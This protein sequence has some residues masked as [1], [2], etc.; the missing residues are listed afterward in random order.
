MRRNLSGV[1]TIE[2]RSSAES[3]P[4]KGGDQCHENNNSRWSTGQTLLRCQNSNV[5]RAGSRFPLDFSHHLHSLAASKFIASLYNC[6]T[7][8][9][10][11]IRRS[12]FDAPWCCHR[13]TSNFLVLRQI[14]QRH[15]RLR[16]YRRKQGL[17]VIIFPKNQNSLNFFAPQQKK[18]FTNN[19]IYKIQISMARNK[20]CNN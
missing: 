5:F 6:R 7:C 11:I 14:S 4:E 17:I 1:S 20:K 10:K 15:T 2:R 8:R 18:K 12:S 9:F 3:S 16:R 19:F 13:R